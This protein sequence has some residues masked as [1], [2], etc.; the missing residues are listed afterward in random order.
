MCLSIPGKVVEIG[1]K[2]VVSYGNEKRIAELS[3]VDINVGDYVIIS[4]KIIMQKIDPK[5]AR[6]FLEVI[7]DK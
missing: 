5:K 1:E 2:I 6:E 3:I 7:D 4:N